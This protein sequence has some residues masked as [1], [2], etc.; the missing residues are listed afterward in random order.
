MVSKKDIAKALFSAGIVVFMK[1]EVTFVGGGRSHIYINQR[2]LRSF[3]QQ[4]A[5]ILAA[6]LQMMKRFS[7][8]DLL[9]DVPTGTIPIVS[10]LSDKTK[11]PQISPRK[12]AKD[13]GL[14]ETI[15]GSYQKGQQ[16]LVVED[17]VT[18]ATSI[19]QTVKFL[20]QAKLRVK[21]ALAMVL[22]NPAGLKNLANEGIT[23]TYFMSL[24]ELINYGVELGYVSKSQ[25]KLAQ[26]ELAQVGKVVG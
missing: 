6:Y 8:P 26:K 20:R 7:R 11:I 12:E 22:R 5:V 2:N 13:H 14:G 17:T 23:L 16:V 9:S 1:E 15:I 4:K 10:S 21:D 25:H 18:L 19:I 3:P 24:E